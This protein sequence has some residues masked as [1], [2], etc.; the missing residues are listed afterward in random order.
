MMYETAAEHMPSGRNPRRSKP[1][2]KPRGSLA[3]AVR[4]HLNYLESKTELTA[5]DKR[6]LDLAIDQLVATAKAA[7]LKVGR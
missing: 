6:S 3:Q 1:V 7:R 4:N 2:R 5:A